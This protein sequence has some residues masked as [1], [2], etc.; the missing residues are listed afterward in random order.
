MEP[1]ENY[2][3]RCKIHIEILVN[4]E[5]EYIRRRKN[6]DSSFDEYS[7]EFEDADFQDAKR[8]I[9]DKTIAF[10]EKSKEKV[11][12]RIKFEFHNARIDTVPLVEADYFYWF[13][14]NCLVEDQRI[15]HRA[16]LDINYACDVEMTN[17]DFKEIAGELTERDD[18]DPMRG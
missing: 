18:D 15:L 1:N 7:E 14:N 6:G 13:D 17:E 10:Y 2:F 9:K 4:R 16:Y 12:A 3:Y 8:W 11:K 5:Q